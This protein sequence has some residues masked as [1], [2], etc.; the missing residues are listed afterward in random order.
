MAKRALHRCQ[1]P[2]CRRRSA[3]P[4]KDLHQHMNVLVRTLDERRR[5]CQASQGSL[6]RTPRL[7]FLVVTV[8]VQQHQVRR[9]IVVIA[10]WHNCGA[11][12]LESI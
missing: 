12:T 8:D 2:D 4:I 3:H 9:G 1:C 5:R 7:V 6:S 10:H 11:R